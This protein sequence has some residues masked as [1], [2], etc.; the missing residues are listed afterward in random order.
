LKRGGD[1][2]LEKMADPSFDDAPVFVA[3]EMMFRAESP[4]RFALARKEQTSAKP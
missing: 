4:V 1:R 2:V 3:D